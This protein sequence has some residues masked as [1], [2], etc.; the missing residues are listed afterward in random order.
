MLAV[1]PKAR[2][3]GVGTALMEECVRRACHMGA[4]QLGLHTM[5]VMQAAVRMYERMGFV[6]TPDLDFYPTRGIIVKGYRRPLND[7]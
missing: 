2:G 5:E 7:G 4:T 3:Q 6:H 1:V